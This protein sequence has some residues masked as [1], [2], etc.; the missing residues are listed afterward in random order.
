MYT[1]TTISTKPCRTHHKI[2]CEVSI[3]HSEPNG[4]GICGYTNTEACGISE[5]QD[6]LVH[7]E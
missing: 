6:L 7:E 4:I 1:G 2:S 5:T 3:S